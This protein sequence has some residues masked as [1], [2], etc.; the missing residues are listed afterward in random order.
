MERN[1]AVDESLM[2]FRGKLCYVQCNPSK[3]ALFGFMFY[4]ICESSS[5]Y[6]VQYSI[7]TGKKPSGAKEI[8]SSAAIV[9]ELLHPYFCKVYAVAL[10]NWYTSPDLFVK[11]I[12]EKTNALGTVRIN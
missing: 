4:K 7:Y 8:P 6:C 9:L 10:D 3:R 5:V 11:L 2:K 1:L 12:D